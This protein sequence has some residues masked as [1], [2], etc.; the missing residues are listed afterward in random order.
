MATKTKADEFAFDLFADFSNDETTS[1]EDL[2]NNIFTRSVSDA[3]NNDVFESD[4][5]DTISASSKSRKIEDFGEKIGGARKDMYTVYKDL[6]AYSSML[7]IAS[8]P[9]SKSWPKPNYLKLLESDIAS[10][11]VD[12]IRALREVVAQIPR[13]KRY[14]WTFERTCTNFREFAVRI[15]NGEYENVQ[16]V[17]KALENHSMYEERIDLSYREK[18]LELAEIYGALGHEQEIPSFKIEHYS[19]FYPPGSFGSGLEPLSNVYVAVVD[20]VP[21][22]ERYPAWSS[23]EEETKSLFLKWL[24]E[25]RD[26][27]LN[28]DQEMVTLSVHT[29]KHQDDKHNFKVYWFKER[30]NDDIK[31]Y[32]ICR[33]IGK[34]VVKIKGPFLNADSAIDYRNTHLD[35]LDEC[36]TAMKSLPNERGD[37]NQ[38]R[39]SSNYYRDGDISPDDFMT[40]F[41]FRG[42]EF[43]NYVEGTR[44][45][46]DL[47]DAYD[48][49][50]DLSLVTGLP[51]RALS[52]GGKLGLAFGA[53]GRGGKNP[54]SAHYES[55]K[56]VINLTKKRGAGSLG[57]E[58]FHALDNML[59][60]EHEKGI[61]SFFTESPF[62]T[63]HAE[64]GNAMYN[65]RTAVSTKTFLV[66]RSNKLDQFKA[67]PYWST[68]REYM[69]R[70][71]ESYLKV[72]L[73]QSGIHNDYLVNILSE[74]SWKKRTTMPYAYPTQKEV[75]T[76]QPY[77]DSLFANIRQRA[78]DEQIVLYSSSADI[79]ANSLENQ[80]IPLDRLSPEETGLLAFG[81]QVLGIQTA[82]YDGDPRLHGHFDTSTSTIFLN[83]SSECDLPWVFAHEAFHAM[84][85]A[86]PLLYKE[87]ME[88]AG[89]VESFSKE[90]IDAY[91][92]ERKKPD[93]SDDVVRQ[94]MLADAFADYTTGRRA[95]IEMAEKQ[96]NTVRRTLNF[97]SRAMNDLKDMFFGDKRSATVDKYPNVV[98][99]RDQFHDLSRGLEYL[100][101]E[102]RHKQHLSKGQ[103]MFLSM[104]AESP[105]IDGFFHSPY[106][107][108]P[109]K[110]FK[111]DC[112]AVEVMSE[113]Y[114]QV[115]KEN[116]AAAVTS[117]SPCG[118]MRYEDRLMASS[119][120][121]GFN[122]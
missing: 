10:W 106:A 25:K 105:K 120:N 37:E 112:E 71:F 55:L 58:W 13:R 99:S 87:I 20:G 23:S 22:S 81:E 46:Q 51:P 113:L 45:Q 93:L 64:L 4:S 30:G 34:N 90:K 111:F 67:K 18:F 83:R 6:L 122:R 41:G 14:R 66:S 12:A 110:Q 92:A 7:D 103:D 104:L 80:L 86:D 102:L 121:H 1:L 114:P 98:L 54:A 33:K 8:V 42:V 119:R 61:A 5:E 38:P 94:E 15:V 117:F 88:L 35:E 60:R 70:A 68:T 28:Q 40:V 48:A 95:V 73:D 21:Y 50:M 59:A 84:K 65:L 107:F 101:E 57:H 76:I 115:A 91:R 53:R 96:P 24:Q 118:G 74:E 11:R 116:I 75:E 72:E 89:G 3:V 9:F 85:E 56:T 36:F 47:N 17:F 49:L 2:K 100:Q 69:A 44:R 108:Q 78:E 19:R 43:G 16:D 27:D 63:S 77:F 32:Y 79:D 97:L 62:G 39:S 82:F 29:K 31:D 26:K 52:L 109:E